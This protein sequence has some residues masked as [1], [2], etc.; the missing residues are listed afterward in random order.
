MVGP[1]T[2]HGLPRKQY[3]RPISLDAV[4][5]QNKFGD[6]KPTATHTKWHW[7]EAELIPLHFE[8]LRRHGWWD[9]NGCWKVSAWSWIQSRRWWSSRTQLATH[10]GSD[11]FVSRQRALEPVQIG[12]A[13]ESNRTTVVESN[14]P[15]LPAAFS[16]SAKSFL[17]PGT[18]NHP[19]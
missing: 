11:K 16:K 7:L 13:S 8:L 3:C 12:R 14:G 4:F 18:Q 5:Q 1:P 2:P 9:R 19:K 15:K 17:N 6:F 10:L